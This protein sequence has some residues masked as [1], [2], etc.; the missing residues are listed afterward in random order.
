MINRI[1][2]L[3]FVTSISVC[4]A[5]DVIVQDDFSAY[6]QGSSGSP[7]WQPYLGEWV[8]RDG[9]CEQI[10]ASRDSAHLF[11]PDCVLTDL[12][13]SVRFKAL[14]EGAGVRTPGLERL[15]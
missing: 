15:A 6:Q 12:D 2:L 10:S 7:K 14:P 5:K 11:R 1:L 9:Q 8:F 4:S 13:F 3:S